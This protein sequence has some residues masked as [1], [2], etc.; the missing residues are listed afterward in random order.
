[1]TYPVTIPYNFDNTLGHLMG[2][3]HTRIL[4]NAIDWLIDEG[5]LADLVDRTRA[6]DPDTGLG[7]WGITFTFSNPDTAMLFK[8]AMKA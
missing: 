5:R 3:Q 4:D 1:M 7:S 8:L 2:Y 6:S